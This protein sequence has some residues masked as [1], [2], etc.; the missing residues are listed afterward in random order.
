LKHN[1][2][3]PLLAHLKN[4]MYHEKEKSVPGWRLKPD[5]RGVAGLGEERVRTFPRNQDR[6]AP[7]IKVFKENADTHYRRGG[8]DLLGIC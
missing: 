2:A 3:L 7:L 5:S 6:K 1:L 8:E 4:S